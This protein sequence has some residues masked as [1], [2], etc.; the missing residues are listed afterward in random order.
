MELHGLSCSRSMAKMVFEA[1]RQVHLQF[2]PKLMVRQGQVLADFAAM[3]TRP[4]KNRNET[5]DLTMK[6]DRKLKEI[7]DL[8]EVNVSDIHAKGLNRVPGSNDLTTHRPSP[9]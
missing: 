7:R 4:A 2:E 9:G 6:M 8:T 5:S 3:V 1:W